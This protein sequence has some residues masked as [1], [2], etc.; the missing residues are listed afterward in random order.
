MKIRTFTI[1]AA[2]AAAATFLPAEA[3]AQKNQPVIM[4]REIAELL[5]DA[6]KGDVKAMFNLGV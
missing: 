3:M 1:M 4:S 2:L 5:E 6:Q